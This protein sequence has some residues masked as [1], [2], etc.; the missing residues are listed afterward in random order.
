MKSKLEERVVQEFPHRCPYC[1][2]P[3]SYD[4]LD[5]RNGENEIRCPSCEKI[6]IRVVGGRFEKGFPRKKPNRKEKKRKSA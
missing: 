4:P 2:Q 5:L 3:I 1:D 6:Y